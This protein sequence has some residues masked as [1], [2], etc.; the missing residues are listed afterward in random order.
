MTNEQGG[1]FFSDVYAR[2]FV[3]N[4]SNNGEQHSENYFLS[5]HISMN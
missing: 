1:G 3:C 5:K 2:D 4:S